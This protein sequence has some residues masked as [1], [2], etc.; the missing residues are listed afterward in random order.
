MST[1]A[2]RDGTT[3]D[4]KASGSASKRGSRS[5]RPRTPA[6]A[7][8]GERAAQSATD[9]DA[10]T[11]GR[12]AA[13]ASAAS[14]APPPGD[15]PAAAVELRRASELTPYARN[16]RTHSPAQVSQIAASITEWGWTTPVLVDEAGVVIAGHGRLLAAQQLG[17]EEVP[18][19]VARGWTEAQ[20]RAY[21]IADNRLAQLAG[22]DAELLAV[23]LD[24]LKVLDFDLALTGLDDLSPIEAQ[25][26]GDVDDGE[27]SDDSSGEIV[28]DEAP[29]PPADPITKP[30]DLWLLGAYWECED[31]GKSY[32]YEDGKEMKECPCG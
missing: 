14:A 15:W 13:A 11:T 5:G 24:D 6:K 19:M 22:W 4:E 7:K 16:A 21:V 29:E 17:L 26:G 30:G 1:Q 10:S 28:E 25:L 18:V 23:E 8:R 3:D 32:D 27:H 31:C 2:E 9:E 12:E 20:R